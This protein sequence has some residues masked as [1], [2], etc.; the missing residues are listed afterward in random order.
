MHTWDYW[1][2][3]DK[4]FTACSLLL[5]KS[6][7][8]YY[9]GRNIKCALRLRWTKRHRA[10]VICQRRVNKTANKMPTLAQRM[11]TIWDGKTCTAFHIKQRLFYQSESLDEWY[12]GGLIWG[13]TLVFAM[14]CCFYF[15]LYNILYF[16]I[17]L[18]LQEGKNEVICMID[19]YTNH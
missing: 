7:R 13:V 3:T 6:L 18:C 12:C 19:I 2:H 4:G 15:I 8:G 9:V 17:I 11:I 1:M 16:Y 10:N 14:Y 5:A